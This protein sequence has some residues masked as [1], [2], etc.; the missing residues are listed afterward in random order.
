MP[1]DYV[2]AVAHAG[3]GVVIVGYTRGAFEG[4]ESATLGDVGS[5]ET[6]L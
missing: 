1:D 5:S 6:G 2:Y 4:F 3:E